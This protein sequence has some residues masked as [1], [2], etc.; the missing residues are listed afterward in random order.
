M[1]RNNA[2]HLA[3]YPSRL[4]FLFR[5]WSILILLA[6]L[7]LIMLYPLSIHLS[8]MVPEPTDP[9]LNVWRM[10]WNVHAFLGG[11]ESITNLFNANI[12]YPFPLTLAYSEHF[13]MM[14][15]QAL[16]FLL[17]ADG[18]LL[19]MNLSV[20][21]TFILSGYAMYLL[22]TN[23]TG[24]RW[25]GLV[26]GLLFAFS[27]HRFGQL[28]HLELLV[29]QWMPLTLLALH[30]TLTRRSTRYPILFIIFFNLQALSGFH[31]T[32]NLTIACALL[33][34]IY[35]LTRRI[36]WRRGLWLAAALSIVVTLLFNWPVW[37]MY[38]RFSDVMGAIRT[39]GEVR[40][41][42]AA[43]TDYLTTIPHNLL[44][45]WTFGR[46]QPEGHQFQPLMPV[47]VVGLLLAII[48][49]TTLFPKLNS[50]SP[51]TTSH[52]TDHASFFAFPTILFLLLV[53]LTGLLLSFGLNE[54]ALG[55][56]LAP[57]LKFSPY[58]WLYK[59]ITF[60]QG[61]RVPGRYGI[62]VV[63]GL[64]GLAGWGMAQIANS[65]LQ[66]VNHLPQA[67]SLILMAFIILEYW[68]A[69]LVGPEFPAGQG[70][71]AV[72][73]WL[74]AETP[75][76]TVV[77]ELPFQGS[78]EF[79]YEYYSS[80]HWRRLANGGTGFTPPI[81]KELR[82]WFNAF[83]DPRSVDV[84][85][86]LGIDLVILHSNSYAP[87]D[88]QRVM[89]DLP[90][91]LPAIEQIQQIGDALILHITPPL[92]R[93][94]PE[95]VQASLAPAQLDGLPHAAAVT[96]HNP[97]PA[98]FVADVQQV[99]R[100]TFTT[101]GGKNFTEPLVTPANETQAVIVPL[102]DEQQVVTLA[103]AWLA[104]LDRAISLEPP[105][106]APPPDHEDDPWQPLGLQFADGPRLA[107]YRLSP[108]NPTACGMLAVSLQWGDGQA[109]DTAI[110]Q[111]LDPF[112]R[113]VI[114]N[115]AQPW[116]NSGGEIDT[117]NLALVAPLPAGRY[118]LRVR[119]KAGDG[120]E[121]LPITE[122]GVT[123]P[124]DQIPPLPL[125][126]HP[127]AHPLTGEAL[128]DPPL[129]GHTIRLLRAK[130]GQEP[131]SAGDWL[132]F[133]L[134]WQAEQPPDS[135]L[136]VFTQL[137]DPAGQVWGQRD[138]WPGGGGYHT[139]LWRP[140][141]PVVDDYAF[142]IQPNAPPGTYRLIVGLYHSD[143][144]ERIPTQSGAD[145]VEIG[146]VVVE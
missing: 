75:P 89:A 95:Q 40:I 143:T 62:L 92:C 133:S 136:T 78:S 88:W 120:A 72:Y 44:Y 144:Q 127:Q 42:S 22:M 137:L 18:H 119:V 146:T 87:E 8:S 13:L 114:E 98:A 53:T 67:I 83:P 81:Y 117:R 76:D 96:Y 116:D 93:A 74:Q 60:F 86:Q 125:V 51:G 108:K 122:D 115:V 47:G 7:T 104:T 129:F 94:K 56:G 106:Q 2:T 36:Y 131:V 11:P 37:R 35:L 17:V 138:N 6:L 58:N 121:R 48:G 73:R 130:L 70:I 68:S 140:G 102:R 27:P 29:T 77:L 141:Q 100:L 113:V 111:I 46:W 80:D 55:T 107:A 23:W 31:Y 128:A 3:R 1:P 97:G 54:Q 132:R 66:L 90:L 50:S 61:I 57:L 142:Q 28:Y 25:A 21:I 118:G 14:S 69:P 24:H 20:L 30:W 16:P 63:L 33:V 32:F 52:V 43:L 15:A 123:I 59:N 103:G 71:A 101:G 110:V 5:E 91:Y 9:L 99:S 26:A 41:Y 45:G 79:I 38:L 139:S 19:G 4:T 82:E 10:Q 134:T 84:I 12:F 85:Q 34:L 64:T 39:P 105:A 124:I 135:E 109:G 65:R 49:L 112:G 126:I 145:F